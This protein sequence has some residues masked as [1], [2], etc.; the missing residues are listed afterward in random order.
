MDNWALIAIVIAESKAAIKPSDLSIEDRFRSAAKVAK[1]HWLVTDE[2]DRF[3]GAVGAVMESFGSD[4]PEFE[5]I[6]IEVESIAK[7][8]AFLNA[9]QAGVGVA[10]VGALEDALNTPADFEPIGLMAIWREVE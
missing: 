7:L 9:A 1:S 6:R 4:S 3:K 10:S 8:N 2:S 5:R